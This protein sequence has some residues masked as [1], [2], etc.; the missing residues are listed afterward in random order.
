MS[1]RELAR[2]VDQHPSNVS[3]WERTGK[4]PKSDVLIVMARALGV[5]VDEILGEPAPRRGAS[6]AGRARETFDRVSTLPRS[7]QKKILDVVDA[8][9]V[10]ATH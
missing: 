9:V 8:L 10:Q 4:L 7:K 5:T 2:Q 3:F 6:P 1:M